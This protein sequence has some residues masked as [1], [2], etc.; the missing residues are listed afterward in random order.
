[1]SERTEELAKTQPTAPAPA[2]TMPMPRPQSRSDEPTR[3]LAVRPETEKT[4]EAPRVATTEESGESPRED[5]HVAAEPPGEALPDVPGTPKPK[6]RAVRIAAGVAGALV[7]AALIAGGA[8][9][10]ELW[11]GHSVPS[12]AGLAASD[13]QALLEQAGFE[14]STR[15]VPVD[16][17]A[18]NAQGS[19]PAQGMRVREG[20]E[21]VL[22]VGVPRTVPAIVGLSLDEARSRLS[23]AGISSLRLEYVNSNEQDGTVLSVSPAAGT[24][25]TQDQPVTITVAQP[26]TVP[27][28]VG[29][30]QDEATRLIA[31]AGLE[32]KIEWREADGDDLEVLET[33][34][35]AGTRTQSGSVVTLTVVA[36]GPSSQ[37]SVSQYLGVSPKDISAY[38]TWKGWTLS[39]GEQVPA[40]NGSEDAAAETGWS[41]DGV[42]TLVFTPH[43]ES[44]R[45]GSILGGLFRQD[46]LA[47]GAAV[48]GVRFE[49]QLAGDD[50]SPAIDSATVN[51]W[52]TRCGLTGLAEV[53]D[54]ATVAARCGKPERTAPKMAVGW[55][56][57]DG[58]V[59][60]VAVVEGKGVSVTCAPKTLYDDVDLS[61]YGQSLGTYLAYAAGYGA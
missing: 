27:D 3:K 50:A 47:Q 12:V 1:M 16:S 45:H 54:G 11:G 57:A 24:Q 14:V 34:P 18:G 32:S 7:T 37:T 9:V 35:S 5:P 49:P 17:G 36:P 48:T 20:G 33:S 42:G 21:V 55:G 29:L 61:D 56:E 15:D 43:P 39:F 25:V 40:R 10:A 52:A 59:W 58:L 28:V 23:H 19:E 2:G 4:R 26:Y 6:R 41:L 31:Q 22:L 30:T 60:S 44:S 13:A 53:L 8:Y 46:V 38:L 51:S